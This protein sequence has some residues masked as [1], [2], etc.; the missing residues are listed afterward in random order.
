[1]DYRLGLDL[2]TNSIGWSILGLDE[3]AEPKNLIDAGVRIFSDGRN[4]IS[5]ISLNVE[6][7]E[8]RRKRRVIYRRKLR[9]RKLFRILQN[10]GLLPLE[11]KDADAVKV[12]DPYELRVM[13]LDYKIKPYGLGRA[14][15][16]LGVRRGFK[17]NRI[18]DNEENK[19]TGEEEEKKD[20]KRIPPSEM[21]LTFKEAIKQNGLRTLGEFLFEQNKKDVVTGRRKGLRFVEGRFLLYPL[22]E[23]YELE[24][25][26]IKK[27]QIKYYPDIAWDKI[28]DVI[29]DQRGLPRQLRGKCEFMDRCPFIKECPGKRADHSCERTFKEMPSSIRFRIL[30]DVYNMEFIDELGVSVPLTEEQR[31]TIISIL[32]RISTNIKFNTLR[33]KLKVKY[34]FNLE[35]NNKEDLKGN[36]IGVKFRDENYFGGIWDT[37]TLADQDEIV[38]KLIEGEKEDEIVTYLR[39]FNLTNEQKW[40]IARYVP[41]RG[42]TSFCKEMTEH[43]V[44][45]MER[46]RVG[47]YAACLKLGI[48]PSKEK[49]KKYD[50]LEYYGKVLTSSTVGGEPEK[51]GEDKPEKRYG[52]I[53]NPTVHVAF[54]QI[55]VVVNELITKYG[56]PEEVVIEVEHDLKASF[57]ERKRIQEKQVKNAKNNERIKKIITEIT[58]IVPPGQKDIQKYKLWEELGGDESSRRCIYCG[59]VIRREELFEGN[60]EIDHILPVSRTMLNSE[61]NLTIAHKSCNNIK[62]GRVPYEAFAQNPKGY[63]WAEISSRVVLL[64]DKNKRKMFDMDAIKEF[65][66]D[67]TEG[68][69]F[70]VNHLTDNT[71]IARLASRYMK[72][73][74][75]NVWV[76]KGRMIKILRDTWDLN[77]LLKRKVSKKDIEEFVLGEEWDEKKREEKIERKIEELRINNYDQR[78]HALNAIVIGLTNRAMVQRIATMS[79]RSMEDKI[80]V[81]DMPFSRDDE[82]SKKIITEKLKTLIVSYKPDHGIEGKLAQETALAK[83]KTEIDGTKMVKEIYVRRFFITS[84][85]KE[86]IDDIVDKKIKKRLKKFIG[87]HP[88]ED[89]KNLLIKFSNKTGIRRIRCKTYAQKTIKIPEPHK[90]NANYIRYYNPDDYLCAIIWRLPAEKSGKFKYTGSYIL[91]VEESK[92]KNPVLVRP[93]RDAKKVCV[94][95]KGDCIELLRDGVYR[96]A[97]IKKFAPAVNGIAVVS[98]YVSGN[99]DDWKLVTTDE[100]IEKGWDNKSSTITSDVLFGKYAARKITVSKIGKIRNTKYPQDN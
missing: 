20:V 21:A 42:T 72:S 65:E 78:H 59:K 9:R 38:E 60:I 36:S 24:F 15:F 92:V 96:K 82:E 3:K 74:C 31:K 12:Y 55:A 77:S 46:K 88:E 7:R 62:N 53:S 85:K 48:E 27:A 30:K 80:K 69:G 28:Y 16:H 95:Y 86:N 50:K 57:E 81:P 94:L 39:K 84:I 22:R 79:A 2:G 61:I 25:Y 51:H 10:E 44:E 23:L 52:K 8:A 41:N 19:K 4:Q 37:L 26:A 35:R 34:H 67:E 29:F 70:N 63:N 99:A 43:L 66:S 64:K 71:Y 76:V 17:S 89:Y 45:V 14:L 13:A 73:I 68:G 58:G 5:K 33:K 11:K 90:D 54:N 18:I 47:Y 100:M 6:R 97:Y 87:W 83:I 98:I 93:C 1:V 56:K 49:V 91:R 75:D 40:L 32:D